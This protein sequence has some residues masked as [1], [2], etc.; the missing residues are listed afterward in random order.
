MRQEEECAALQSSSLQPSPFARLK[1]QCTNNR[2]RAQTPTPSPTQTIRHLAG[3][4][5]R[6]SFLATN[7]HRRLAVAVSTQPS[8]QYLSVPAA[9]TEKILQR[10]ERTEGLRCKW[11][12]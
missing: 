1:S 8:H 2:T 9:P 12:W 5:E 3:W 11:R 6:C 7:A 10:S 4:C